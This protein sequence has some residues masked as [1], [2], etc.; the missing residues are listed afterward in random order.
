MKNNVVEILNFLFKK[1][2]MQNK[3]IA[4]AAA[5]VDEDVMRQ[6]ELNGFAAEDVNDA[7]TWFINLLMQQFINNNTL[8]QSDAVRIF[9]QGEMD[10]VSEAGCSFILFLERVGVL[11][12]KTREIVITQVMQLPQNEC[13]LDDIKWV[14]LMVLLSQGEM[15]GGNQ[16]L[17][18]YA[19]CLGQ[20]YKC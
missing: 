4:A 7:F 13:S 5:V 16:T 6:L 3:N 11:S 19:L 10:K 9:A 18:K 2:L 14:V 1:Y 15:D 20:Q 17:E 12:S 8:E